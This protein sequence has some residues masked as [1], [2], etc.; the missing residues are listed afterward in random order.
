MRKIPWT[1]I[2]LGVTIKNLHMDIFV[3]PDHKP[4]LLLIYKLCCNNHW[5]K[6]P[7]TLPQNS[8]NTHHYCSKFYELFVHLSHTIVL[9]VLCSTGRSLLPSLA[10]THH[11]DFQWRKMNDDVIFIFNKDS[12]NIITFNWTKMLLIPTAIL[13]FQLLTFIFIAVNLSQAVTT[14][15]MLLA[16]LIEII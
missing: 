2:P 13:W 7:I 3:D 8:L 10:C 1:K 16:I 4:I 12:I 15:R 14:L 9:K 5:V 6:R 11:R